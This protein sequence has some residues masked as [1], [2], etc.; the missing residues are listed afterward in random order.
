MPCPKSSE[1]DVLSDCDESHA[2]SESE[3]D[4]SEK[5]SEA[6]GERRWEWRFQL[7]LQDAMGPRNGEKATIE[8]Y[9]AGQDA[10][11][12]LKLDAEK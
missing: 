4:N 12:L 3:T 9:V 6:G 5:H 10:E 1:F 7:S 8:V 2:E 11:C